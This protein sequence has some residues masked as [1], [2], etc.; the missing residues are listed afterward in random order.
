MADD[1][2]II[3]IQLIAIFFIA[4]ALFSLLPKHSVGAL[5]IAI[6]LMLL[7]A[8][9]DAVELVNN[10]V[11]AIFGPQHLPKLDFSKSIPPECATVVAVPTL[12]LNQEQVRKLVA[13]L[14]VRFL[15]NRGANLH[16]ALLTDLPDS[17]SKPHENDSHPLVELAIELIEELNAKYASTKSGSFLLLHRHRI[18][19][20]RQGVWMGWERK[21]G[22][23]LD[24]NK[25]LVDGDD[26]F[27][28]KAGNIEALRR[29]RYVLT[30]DS[31]TQL[32][33]DAAAKLIGALHTR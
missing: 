1:F 14:E 10:T 6:V 28:I 20:T 16:F 11:T 23:L 24:L 7:P 29:V 5:A 31:D 21:R 30:L 3:G 22:K 18:F 4:A 9:Q 17:V 26:A 19:N 12:L 2:Y 32:P 33:R 8:M 27:P 13:D 25:L 15:A